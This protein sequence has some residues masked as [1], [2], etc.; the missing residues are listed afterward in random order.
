MR[1]NAALGVLLLACGLGVA[2]LMPWAAASAQAGAAA[3]GAPPV[4]LPGPP[5]GTLPAPGAA[6][7]VPAEPARGR[8]LYETH[9][10]ACHNTQVHWRDRREVR[11][12][13][14]LQMQVARWQA[15]TGLSWSG[16]DILEVSRYLNDTVYKLPAPGGRAAPGKA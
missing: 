11:D 12:W 6:P 1:R 14:S 2:T 8:L 15:N 13:P 16:D 7:V 9:C 3:A 5:P 10:I 4:T